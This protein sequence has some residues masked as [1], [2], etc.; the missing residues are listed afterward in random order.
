[1]YGVIKEAVVTEKAKRL[2]LQGWQVFSVDPK[3]TKPEITKALETLYGAKVSAVRIVKV[4]PKFKSGAK[5]GM[6][7][8]RAAA[9]KAYV[10]LDKPVAQL[11]KVK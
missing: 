4:Q 9:V 11:A 7:R 2:E 10:K 6:V 1:M 8:R 3:A 5:R